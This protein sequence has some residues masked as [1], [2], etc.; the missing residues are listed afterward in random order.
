MTRL[1]IAL[2]LLCLSSLSWAERR[3]PVLR[4]GTPPVRLRAPILRSE[5]APIHSAA[6]AKGL[7]LTPTAE[8]KRDATRGLTRAQQ[9]RLQRVIELLKNGKQEPALREWQG[10]VGQLRGVMG[11]PGGANI[12]AMIYYVM[13]QAII[14]RDEQKRYWLEKLQMQNTIGEALSEHLDELRAASE[15]LKEGPPRRPSSAPIALNAPVVVQSRNAPPRLTFR[16]KRLSSETQVAAEIAAYEKQLQT[17]TDMSQMM[18][19]Q[20]QQTMQKR[21]QAFQML[22]NLMKN[23]HDTA[24][25]IIQNMR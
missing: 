13:R 9:A 20:L 8:L 12:M 19:L 2:A 24:K 6:A 10:F 1:T 17:Q 21:Q 11:S 14:E 4:R 25:A 22:S 15:K 23:M 18:M 3:P 5:A 7:F 16:T